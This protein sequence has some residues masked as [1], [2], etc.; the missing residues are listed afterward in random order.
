MKLLVVTPF[1]ENHGGGVEKVAHEVISELVPLGWSVVWVSSRS[2]E[3]NDIDDFDGFRR[4]PVSSSNFLEKKVGIPY[5]IWGCRAFVLLWS[6]IKTTD[7]LM[8]HESLYV[9]SIYST[10]IA[11]L[12]RK[13]IV[14]VQHIGLV[15]YSSHFAKWAMSVGNA[16]V[17][18]VVHK[19]ATKIVFISNTARVYFN[20][21][22]Q[23][24]K[25][26]LIPNGLDS[27]VFNDDARSGLDIGGRRP[28]VLFVGRFVEKKGLD[29][30]RALANAMTD[31][32]FYLAGEGVI[33]PRVWRLD[34][35]YILG[36][37]N[38]KE[39]A[40]QYNSA[41]LLILPSVGE[42]FPLVVQEAM[43]TGLAP[44]ISEEVAK[45]LPGVVEHVYFVGG[46]K[47]D[48]DA[49]LDWKELIVHALESERDVNIKVRRAKFARES[50]SWK[51]CA[52]NYNELLR[53][54]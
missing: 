47:G 2:Q 24:K 22:L 36:Y 20:F 27:T 16:C 12:H 37:L 21:Q 29:I 43:A 28:R 50:W 3:N 18:R 23:D 25:I 45:A 4:Y 26:R 13:P 5:P 7:V 52:E 17:A 1:F 32:D 49:F 31:I 33:D 34:N 19:L 11:R 9:S 51:I 44:L 41:D 53:N 46:N 10:L 42:G 30:V 40:V 8:I 6:Q 14:L 54:I 15:P 35:V 38:K 39:L 48:M